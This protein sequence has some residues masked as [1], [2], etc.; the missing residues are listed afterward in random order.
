MSTTFDEDEDIET[1]YADKAEWADVVP[2]Q[3]YEGVAPLAPIFYSPAYKDATDYF[4]GV[5]KTGEK[6]ARVLE[7]TEHII[8]MNPAHYSAW[9]YRY[10]TLIALGSPL[11]DELRLMDKYAI[12]FL[13]TYQVWHHRRLL[14]TAL[15]STDAAAAELNF[16]ARALGADAKNY[17]TWSYRQW[18][19]AHFNN[20]AR[21]WAGERAWVEE[22]LDKDVRNNSAWHHRF[23]V[24]W[25]AGVR[26]GDEDREEVLKRELAFAKE[27]IALAP[28]NLSAW[29]YF[30]GVL[31]HTHTPF[32][33]LTA[34][35]EPYTAAEPPTTT[36]EQS[37]LD[38]ENPLPSEG[39]DLP[40]VCA[41]EFL[42]DIHEQAGG[43]QTAKAV[44]IW[45][46]LAN[47]HDTMR[48]KYWEYRIREA[49]QAK[50]S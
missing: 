26:A 36:K 39:A 50:A 46:T 27:K 24:V 21:L 6:S 17:H 1:L 9:Q 40:S 23:F 37:V 41:L 33:L 12:D 8:R 4:R 35:V 34:F 7:L 32:A 10:H 11:E 15:R 18:V 28:N 48:K 38:L 47:K 5:V 30:R 3:Q 31:E 22:L 13:K 45:K 44:E 2:V 19:L 20:E 49:L 42:A 14:L 43:D 16:I 29:N 25:L